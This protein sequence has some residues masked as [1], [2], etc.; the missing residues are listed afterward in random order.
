[1]E[2]KKEKL[3][4]ES[5]RNMIKE[6][7]TSILNEQ[8]DVEVEDDENVDVDVEK[9]VDVD[10]KDEVDVDDESVES[11]IE[12]KTSVPGMDSDTDAVLGLLTKASEEADAFTDDP[13]LKTQ[14]GNV[15]TYFTRKHVAQV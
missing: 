14:I 6:K 15:I 7:I 9:D 3:T 5:L 13:E 12:V 10:V 1:M 8:E 11:D 4:K 2:D